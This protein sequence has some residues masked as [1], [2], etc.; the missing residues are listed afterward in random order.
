MTAKKPKAVETGP[1]P[2]EVAAELAELD[3][4]ATGLEAGSTVKNPAAR[5]ALA[6]AAAISQLHLRALNAR[7]SAGRLGAEESRTI[8]AV[9]SGLK[10]LLA[11]LGHVAGKTGPAEED[12]EG[13]KPPKPGKK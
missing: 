4:L 13:F 11:E 10:R 5:R 6:E 1:S 2:A 3:K 8:P 7:R 9:V 12:A